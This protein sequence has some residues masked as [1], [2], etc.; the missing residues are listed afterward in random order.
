MELRLAAIVAIALATPAAA[1]IVPSEGVWHLTG[2]VTA[3]GCA[4]RCVS[5]RV[6]VDQ[7]V[8]V[9]SAQLTG[10]EG[11]VTACS[12]G[13]S[14]AEFDGLSTLV[15]ARRGWLRIRIVDRPRF[16]QL[17]RRCVGYPSL[18]L[19]P[20]SARVRVAPDGRSFDEVV[21]VS[22][23]VA[24]YGRTATFSARGRIHAEWVRAAASV[25]GSP[26]A[27]V[28]ARVLDAALAGE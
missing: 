14:T 8:V 12:G 15:P 3:T 23:S 1:E 6:R 17:M 25:L 10:G 27:A 2:H 28:V 24:V 7:E 13:V 9:T 16:R 4:D 22:G 5:K 19:G 20:L 18:R 21:F 26:R 11:L